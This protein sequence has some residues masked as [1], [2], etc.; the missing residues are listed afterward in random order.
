MPRPLDGTLMTEESIVS[1]PV[2]SAPVE[3][4]QVSVESSAPSV[5]VTSSQPSTIEAV[6]TETKPILAVDNTVVEPSNDVAKDAPI[7]EPE[8]LPLPNYEFTLPEGVVTD[9]PNFKQFTEKLGSLQN[10]SK[11]E[12]AVMQKFGQEMIDMHIAEIQSVLKSQNTASWDWFNNRNKEWMESSKNDPVI[13]G[14]NFEATTDA[15]IKA[16]RLY[17]GSKAQQNE[18][19]KVLQETGVE[20]HPS[21]LRL[22]SNVTRVAAR[23]G[24][25]TTSKVVPVQ[26]FNPANAMYGGSTK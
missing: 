23:E 26:P 10:L 6:A 11:A 14:D 7:V 18:L 8:T 17:G 9:N 25:P 24:S 16:I 20:N 2:S 21:L 19:A 1:A 12:Q 3:S 15:A 5:D 22:L 4:S 13:G